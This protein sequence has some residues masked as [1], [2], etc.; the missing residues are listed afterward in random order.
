MKWK[1]KQAVVLIALVSA[2][3]V[4]SAAA[5]GAA[6]MKEEIP[7]WASE[8]IAVWQELGLLKG[9]ERGQVLPYEKVKKA[10]FVAFINRVFQYKAQSGESFKDVPQ[11][12]WYAADISKAV[13]SGA[14]IGDGDRRI[15]PLEYLTREKAAIIVQRVFQ[16]P[17]ANDETS[18]FKDDDDISSWAK[19][20]V[21]ALKEKGYMEGTPAGEFLPKKSLSRAEAV[22]MIH[23]AMGRLI[24]DH[25][26][27][28]DVTGDNLVVN[29]AG[30]TFAAM[31]LTGDMYI[32]PGVGD[33][34]LSISDSD[35]AGTLF[36]NGGGAESIYISNSM[37]NKLVILKPLSPVRVVLSGTTHVSTIIVRSDSELVVENEA[38][39]EEL[40]A[41][42]AVEVS[43]KGMIESAVIHA[44]G[45]VFEHS[46]RQWALNGNKTK[47]AGKLVTEDGSVKSPIIIY[48]SP[49]P[50]P[51]TVKEP[52]HYT[53]AEATE[54]FGSDGAEGLVK[55]YIAFLEDPTYTP[56]I[57][58][59]NVSMPDF[60]NA[61]TFVDYQFEVQPS[62]FATMPAVNT[63]LLNEDRTM[64]W[65]GTDEGIT[66][67]S[68]G[69]NRMK[70]YSKEGGQLLDDKV[71]LL[72][73]DGDA[74]V[75][76]ITETG[77]THIYQ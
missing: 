51:G 53:Y 66:S 18:L 22:K 54:Q 11:D 28:S 4:T 26:S 31:D 68:L 55:R 35:I 13:A 19:E 21:Y 37:V 30:G 59:P 6:A 12:A 38:S 9:N 64:L 67:I 20:A 61:V 14:I 5:T 42:A 49:N 46:P 60:A 56:S 44:S 73:S 3:S 47:I 34:D 76:V 16:V 58:N 23:N 43:G 10:E 1:W 17:T 69:N 41:H 33:G 71:L 36:V 32:A 52:D 72:L 27:Y 74:G 63:S 57:A 24:A 29:T 2:M 8:E 15:A 45:V 48:P 75:F 62:I 25:E 39:V 7:E 70:S 65:I 50:N 77:V 40:H